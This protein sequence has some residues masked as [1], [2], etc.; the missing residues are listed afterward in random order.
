MEETNRYQKVKQH[1]KDNKKVYFAA[2][3]G[4]VVGAVGVFFA[5]GGHVMIVDGA[6]LIHLQYKSPN[7]NV[8]LDRR[9]CPDP[10]PVRDKSTGE[11]YGSINR[12]AAMTKTAYAAIRND[13]HGAQKRFERLPDSV[14]A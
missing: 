6:K 11:V 2:G 14:F 8:I 7:V 12:A 10:I 3:G 9:A 1:L 13:A 4:M 5:T